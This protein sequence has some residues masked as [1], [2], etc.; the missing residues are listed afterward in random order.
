MP[1]WS[2]QADKDAWHWGPATY[3]R[4]GNVV[5]LLYMGGQK[6]REKAYQEFLDIKRM[7]IVPEFEE[8]ISKLD[9]FRISNGTPSLSEV[10]QQIHKER[11]PQS[12]W[13]PAEGKKENDTMLPEMKYNKVSK[14]KIL[15]DLIC[16]KL[17]V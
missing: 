11:T 2:G 16:G 7:F 3:K 12:K 1:T 4:L 14:Y 13:L 5:Y 9:A 10:I 17:N 8:Y 15:I 6:N